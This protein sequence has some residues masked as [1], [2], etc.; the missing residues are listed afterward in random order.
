MQLPKN[1]DQEKFTL[2]LRQPNWKILISDKFI[3]LV[4]HCPSSLQES[5]IGIIKLWDHSGECRWSMAVTTLVPIHGP[6]KCKL[7]VVV[8]KY[9][10]PS[11]VQGGGNCV[12]LIITTDQH[13]SF[14]FHG[15]M[16]LG[17]FWYVPVPFWCKRL[18]WKITASEMYAY[19]ISNYIFGA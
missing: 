18:I 13:C 14:C 5:G 15:E 9:K 6:Q 8:F 7:M 2:N 11:S 3:E 1:W 17:R 12:C 19:A 16:R 4:E 10:A